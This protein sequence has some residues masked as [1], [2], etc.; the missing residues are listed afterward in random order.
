[1]GWLC[2][3]GLVWA[4][5]ATAQAQAPT[6][7]PSPTGDKMD[8]VKAAAQVPLSD[9]PERYRDSVKTTIEKPALF[10]H[11]PLESFAC[12]PHVYYWLLEHPDRGVVAWRRLGAQCVMINDRGAGRF[13]WSDEHGSDL[14]WETVYQSNECR[15]WYAEG[16][17]RPAPLLPL[18][19]VK[20][21]VVLRYG[22][23]TGANG[24]K[25]MQHQACMFL[26]TDSAGA[27]LATKLLGSAAPRMAEQC[28][29]QMQMF[30]SGLAWYVHRYPDRAANLLMASGP[31][32][33]SLPAAYKT[34][35][36]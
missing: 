1:M 4:N 30:F 21:V 13:G 18:V 25:L 26:Y 23:H 31:A 35:G 12:Q 29:T 6:R 36:N 16:K 7:V 28:V 2:L 10:T 19:P 15:I 34:R 24:G 3:A 32:D 22:E 33:V 27:A 20:T 8:K 14:Q 5:G 17:V 11:G 9:I